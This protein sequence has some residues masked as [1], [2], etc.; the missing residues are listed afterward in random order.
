MSDEPPVAPEPLDK[1]DLDGCD[2]EFAEGA[3]TRDEDLPP[4]FGGVA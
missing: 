2:L 3:Q 1:D 4:S